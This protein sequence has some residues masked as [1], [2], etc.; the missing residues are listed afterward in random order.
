MPAGIRPESGEVTFTD[1]ADTGTV[2]F[3]KY[4]KPG[5]FSEFA[6]LGF[7]QFTH[8]EKRFCQLLVTDGIQEV[9]LI[10]IVVNTA[11]ADGVCHP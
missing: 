4:I 2:L 1:K 8:G 10:L 6:H 11:S 5:L 7:F 9:T 3:I